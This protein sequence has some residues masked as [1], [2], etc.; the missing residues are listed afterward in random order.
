MI[1]ARLLSVLALALV[2]SGC[3]R[4]APTAP[5]PLATAARAPMPIRLAL[6]GDGLIAVMADGGATQPLPFQRP[7]SQTLVTMTRAELTRG[8]ES[9]NTECGAGPLTFVEWP[10]GLSLVFQDDRFAGWTVDKAGLTT[11]D[12]VGVGSTRAELLAAR[13]SMEVQESTLGAEFL[14]GDIGGLFDG[15]GPNAKITTLWAGTTCMFR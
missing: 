5:P 6:S 13:P 9:V 11:M 2:L 8:K 1:H 14:A 15:K 12:G 7:K 3:D 4:P 10:D